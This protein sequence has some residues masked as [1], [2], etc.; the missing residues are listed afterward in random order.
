MS[1]IAISQQRD[2]LLGPIRLKTRQS[3]I[4]RTL[5]LLS[6]NSPQI[7]VDGDRGQVYISLISM[8]RKSP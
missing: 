6:A 3:A 8:K 1:E 2:S 5:L 4:G 7:S